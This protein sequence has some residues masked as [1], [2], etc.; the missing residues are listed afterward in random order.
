M[1]SSAKKRTKDQWSLG[2]LAGDL[3]EL[4]NELL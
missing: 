1:V 2:N 4:L 3:L